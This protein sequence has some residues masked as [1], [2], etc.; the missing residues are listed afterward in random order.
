M[1]Q[2]AAV[3]FYPG[4]DQH[5]LLNRSTQ[6]FY[7]DDMV[8]IFRTLQSLGYQLYVIDASLAETELMKARIPIDIQ[9]IFDSPDMTALPTASFAVSN[10]H[11]SDMI[12][13]TAIY[14]YDTVLPRKPQPTPDE[15]I[16]QLAVLLGTE[17][18]RVYLLGSGY[19]NPITQDNLGLVNSGNYINIRPGE[20]GTAG[21]LA[22]H[23]AQVNGIDGHIDVIYTDADYDV[24]DRE[25][26][27][28][29]H[30]INYHPL[31]NQQTTPAV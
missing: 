5:D 10:Y 26:I 16:E 9:L 4:P 7:R 18:N 19:S 29:M 21:Q 17:K 22:L 2:T 1:A 15:L 28:I 31:S 3:L 30:N 24:R 12:P 13:L 14:S 25:F 27:S 8:S 23:H 20:V 6:G 11:T